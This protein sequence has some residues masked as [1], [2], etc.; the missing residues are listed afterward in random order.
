M[1]KAL[2]RR[3]LAVELVDFN[4]RVEEASVR[5]NG[6]ETRAGGFRCQVGLG[7]LPAALSSGKVNPP[8]FGPV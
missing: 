8:I 2:T 3:R 1:A 4:H 6:K 7:Q 5:V